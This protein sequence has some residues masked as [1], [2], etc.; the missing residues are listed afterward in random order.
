MVSVIL[1]K[2]LNHIIMKRIK[3]M[4]LLLIG[5]LLILGCTS[6]DDAQVVID[7]NTGTNVTP[8]NQGSDIQRTFLGKV[9]DDGGNDVSGAQ[10]TIGNSTVMTDVKGVFIIENTNVKSK[11]AY[12][13]VLKNGF[14]QALKTTVPTSGVNNVSITLI[15][16]TPDVV[17]ATGAVSEVS[18]LNGTKI[19]FDGNFSDTSGVAYSGNVNVSMYYLDAGD[20]DLG[21]K[22]PGNLQAENTNESEGVLETYGMLN[23]ELTGDSGQ[24]LNIA[25][26][27]TAQIEVPI[28]STVSASAP[29]TIPLW[30]FDET[31][32]YWVEEGFATK[33]GA[34]YVGDVSH[35]SW[36]NCDAFFPTTDLCMTVVDASGLPLAN[37]TVTL[38]FS[39]TTFPR[40]GISN[41]NGVICGLIPSNEIITANVLDSC[42]NSIF[43]STIGPFSSTGNTTTITIPTGSI[44][45]TNVIGDFYDC[46]NNPIT[47]GYVEIIYGSNVSYQYITNGE[48]DINTV[49]CSANTSFTLEGVDYD[50]LQSTGLLNQTF[51]L[52]ITDVGSI[53]SCNTVDEFI[54]FQLNSDPVEIYVQADS[55]DTGTNGFSIIGLG[56]GQTTEINISL[57]ANTPGIYDYATSSIN[58]YEN[59]VAQFVI[60]TFEINISAFGANVND[61]IDFTY[62]GTMLDT[63][64][65][66]VHNVS[67]SAHIKRD[68]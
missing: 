3:K 25:S 1:K 42:G 22:M 10:V 26:G 52:P 33:I 55:Y 39:G 35:F 28:N 6:D 32:G 63:T 54:T 60:Q 57:N 65:N 47:N 9:V 44:S 17:I 67:G 43:S 34:K 66:T 45:T 61:Y 21:S 12:I 18:M 48:I 58:F 5:L 2:K 24:E 56:N 27:S 4:K 37:V 13:K 46:S 49:V 64:T 14:Y 68:F 59:S 53:I 31:K 30:H 16:K 23:V 50:A 38:V 41:P 11:Q 62:N 15:A 40:Q 29:S 20:P 36:W 51:T 19:T 8:I 7:N